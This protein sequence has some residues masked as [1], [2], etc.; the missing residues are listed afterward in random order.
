MYL[1]NAQQIV[2]I[3][4]RRIYS[5]VSKPDTT[6]VTQHIPRLVTSHQMFLIS[7]VSHNT[8]KP[9]NNSCVSDF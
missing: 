7:I 4:Q 1:R 8:T 5:P 9:R 3:H 6:V 2:E